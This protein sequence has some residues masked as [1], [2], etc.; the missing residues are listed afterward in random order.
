MWATNCKQKPK[1]LK[2]QF[3]AQGVDC[4]LMKDFACIKKN[5]LH[6]SNMYDI[7]I[8]M[9]YKN[10]TIYCRRSLSNLT[11]MKIFTVVNREYIY[12]FFL[13]QTIKRSFCFYHI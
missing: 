4:T 8:Y 9:I 13:I 2:E 12:T 3:L 6:L 10:K 11:F 1:G 5:M 7:S